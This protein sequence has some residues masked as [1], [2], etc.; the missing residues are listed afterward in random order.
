MATDADKHNFV[1]LDAPPPQTAQSRILIQP[2]T[3][4]Y[5]S[6][7]DFERTKNLVKT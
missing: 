6:K 2:L 7:F 3:R 5:N 4:P 1:P